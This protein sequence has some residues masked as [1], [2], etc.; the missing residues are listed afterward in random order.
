MKDEK[1][2]GP[3]FPRSDF[4]SDTHF[5]ASAQDGMSLRDWF[6][7]QALSGLC[8]K[9][10]RHPRQNYCEEEDLAMAATAYAIAD[11]MLAVRARKPQ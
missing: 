10:G 8:A 1:D 9:Y 2:G 3:A 4:H 5:T 11:G 7:G 6:A